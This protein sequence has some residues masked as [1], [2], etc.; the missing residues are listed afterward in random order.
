MKL[1]IVSVQPFI[2]DTHVEDLMPHTVAACA[3]L[4]ITVSTTAT[5]LRVLLLGQVSVAIHLYRIDQEMY[6][7]APATWAFTFSM[8]EVSYRASCY[9]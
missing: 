4:T 9:Y 5:V 1:V 7:M 3:S 8:N 2:T 6:S